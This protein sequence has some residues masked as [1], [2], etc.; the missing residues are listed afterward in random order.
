MVAIQKREKKLTRVSFAIP[1]HVVALRGSYCL[2]IQ[3]QNKHTPGLGGAFDVRDILC[4][5]VIIDGEVV[6]VVEFLNK[7]PDTEPKRKDSSS[8]L[9]TNRALSS[10]VTLTRKTTKVNCQVS[11]F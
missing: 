5:P 7:I 2:Y 9:P 8:A 1:I 4:A 6:A 10:P 11:F 3:N